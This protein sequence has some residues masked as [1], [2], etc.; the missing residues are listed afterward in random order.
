[1]AR[2]A[3]SLMFWGVPKSGS[4]ASREMMSRPAALSARALAL[5]TAVAEGL[6]RRKVADSTNIG[7]RLGLRGKAALFTA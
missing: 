7:A 2:T 4:P 6:M 5:A 3:A 1:M